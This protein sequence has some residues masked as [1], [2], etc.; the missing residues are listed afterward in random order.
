MKHNV[1]D[2]LYYNEEYKYIFGLLWNCGGTDYTV[3]GCHS[4]ATEW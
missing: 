2:L 1:K 3:A 4:L